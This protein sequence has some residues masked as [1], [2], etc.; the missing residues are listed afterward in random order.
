MSNRADRSNH[1]LEKTSFEKEFVPYNIVADKVIKAN[2]GLKRKSSMELVVVSE[3][4]RGYRSVNV[5]KAFEELVDAG[6]V[7]YFAMKREK[8]SQ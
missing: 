1:L 4:S 5:A 3:N 7:I 2:H 8:V 6:A